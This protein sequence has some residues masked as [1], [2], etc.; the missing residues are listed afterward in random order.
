V[1]DQSEFH[2][3]LQQTLGGTYAIERELGGGGMSRVFV[4]N[5]T[6]LGRAVVIKVVAPE[7]AEGV[8]AERFTR[9]VK[10]AARLQ[11]AN[12][13]PLLSA[14]EVAGLPYYTMPFVRGETLRAR[15]SRG[16]VPLSETVSILR[17]IARALSHAHSQS[18]VHRDI[19]PENVLLSGG[20]AMVADFG[21]AKAV[22]D[23]RTQD[24]AT[25][26]LLTHAGISIG[27]PAYMAP[28]QALG[29]PNTDLRADVYSWGVI[30]YELL[31]GVHPFAA[32]TSTHALIKAHITQIPAALTAHRHDVPLTLGSVVMRCLEKAAAQRPQSADELLNALEGITTPVSD[33]AVRANVH[34]EGSSLGRKAAVVVTA[35]LAVSVAL[36]AI[37]RE[38][39]AVVPVASL[40]ASGTPAPIKSLVVLPFESTGGDTANAYFAEGMA[41][42]VSTALTK[43]SGL[44]IAGRI[45][46]LTFKGKHATAQE[47]GKALGVGAV[48]DG[49]VRRAGDKLR[50]STQL[51]NA[52]DGLVMWSETYERDVKDVFAVQDD[53]SK[54]IVSALRI[55]LGSGGNVATAAR[56]TANVDAYDLYLRGMYFYQRRGPGLRRAIDYFQQAIA[57]DPSF[58][59]AHAGL[60]LTWTT[61][62]LYSNTPMTVVI[63]KALAEAQRALALDSNSVDGLVAVGLAQM[64][65]H[66]WSESERAYREALKNDPDSFLAHFWLGRLLVVLGKVDESVNELRRS[67]VL[68]PLNAPTLA[69]TAFFLSIGG[70]HAEALA[71]ADRAFELD[72][73]LN[74][75]QSYS[76]FA[77]LNA[78]RTR[79]MRELAERILPNPADI[80]TLSA[81]TYAIGRSGDTLRARALVQRL[82]RDHAGESRYQSALTRAL[83]GVGDTA[84]AMAAMERAVALGESGVVN[85]PLPDAMY[86]PVRSSLRF[87]AIVKSLGLDVTLLT[88]PKGGRLR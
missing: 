32:A 22:S 59:R 13:V 68:D 58:A 7:L 2:F 74:A 37:T 26:T 43:L 47:V 6:A 85:H 4:A 69:T 14:G 63:P 46:A 79:E 77:L 51:T 78:G 62:G 34:L 44:Q 82:V 57:K 12:I 30:A 61:F 20:A 8:S 19:K 3:R 71:D 10:L 75:T 28:E 67:K 84:G 33:G 52:T 70:H 27:T 39:D 64:Y 36:W 24:G 50:V 9:E 66:R 25:A 83:F 76:V 80:S 18:V 88:S 56:G 55:T 15:L 81:I 29:D 5:E 73:T 35:A 45:S 41:D 86:D 48:L 72:S 53:I 21:I 31:A 1:T 60:G 42:E 49:T 23:A 40:T 87:A 11:H 38:Q 17:D 16:P 65:A 54:A